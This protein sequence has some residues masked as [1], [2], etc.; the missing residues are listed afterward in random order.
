MSKKIKEY[1]ER[2]KNLEEEVKAQKKEIEE[3]VDHLK[4]IQA[5]F[6]NY[7]KRVEKGNE[8]A[9]IDG[10]AEIVSDLLPL[11]DEFEIAL[12]NTNDGGLRMLYDK[13]M[14]TLRG[15]GLRVIEAE[16]F[17]PRFH[18]VAMKE[19]SDLP[20]GK[21]VRILRKGYEFMG[22][23]IRPCSVVVSSGTGEEVV[24]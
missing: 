7:R 15:H 11:I 4:R 2:L 5:E 1:E 17:D 3:Y 8:Q 23:T 9:K 6:D 16:E 19:K 22:R 18:E 10:K 13:L 20:E 21:I 14:A 24:S 12:T